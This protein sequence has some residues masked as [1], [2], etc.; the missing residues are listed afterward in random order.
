MVAAPLPAKFFSRENE[1]SVIQVSTS[2]V[3]VT[4]VAVNQPPTISSS[5]NEFSV[6]T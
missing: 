6:Q 4:I 5:L 3:D 1:P 2:T